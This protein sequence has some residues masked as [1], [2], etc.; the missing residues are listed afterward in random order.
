M[1]DHPM[2]A[3][4]WRGWVATADA[5]AYATYIDATGIAAY[6]GTPGNRGALMLRRDLADDRT[7]FVTFSLWDSMASIEAFAGA[8]PERAVFYPEDDRFLVD[9]ELTVDHFEV[10][11]AAM[12]GLEPDA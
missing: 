11:R 12:P 4:T 9:R 3:R 6:R 8:H 7:E 5:D 10:V 1:E 2:L